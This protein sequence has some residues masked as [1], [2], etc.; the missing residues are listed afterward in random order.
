MS[1]AA[2]QNKLTLHFSRLYLLDSM[3]ILIKLWQAHCVN[4]LVFVFFL[5]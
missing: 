3:Y 1:S 2:L 5:Y 4:N